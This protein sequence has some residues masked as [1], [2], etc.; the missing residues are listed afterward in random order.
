MEGEGADRKRIIIEECFVNYTEECLVSVGS[1][2]ILSILQ[3]CKKT[4]IC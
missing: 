2:S 4:I 3:A 1:P